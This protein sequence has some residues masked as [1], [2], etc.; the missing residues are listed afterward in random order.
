MGCL[1]TTPPFLPLPWFA[2]RTL[3]LD[4]QAK[5]LAASTEWRAAAARNHFQPEQLLHYR[6]M[7]LIQIA[8]GLIQAR[9]E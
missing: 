5:T 8:R 3:G 9:T 2:L 6:L 4:K 1:R 7:G